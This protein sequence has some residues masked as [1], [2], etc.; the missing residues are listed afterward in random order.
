MENKLKNKIDRV[1]D[2]DAA[3]VILTLAWPTM[4]ESL[5]DTAV[6]Y[7]DTAMVGSLGTAATAAVGCTSTVGWLVG[8]SVSALG[9]GFLSYIAKALG[10]K[11]RESARR[12]AAQAVTVTA[13]VGLLF[14]VLTM[15][16]A[17]YVPVWMKADES[18]RK[19]ASVY[20][21]ILYAP[22]LFRSAKIIFG[23]LLRAAGDTKTPMRVGIGMNLI[24]VVLN[25]FLIYSS[26]PLW[27]LG[28]R[29]IYIYGAGLGVVGAALA[30][31]ISFVFGGIVIGRALWRHETISP[32]GHSYKPDGEILKPCLK[33]ALPN[34]L[35][36]FCTS[37]GY[38]VFASM[39][40][41]LG[42]L[43]TAAHTVA[44][45]V[46]SA[47]YIPG[48]G[49]Q[50]AAAT[51]TG[52]CIGAK[53]RARLKKLTANIERLEAAMMVVSG[54]LLF[55]FAPQMVS[56]FSDDPRVIALGGRVLRMVALS[57]PFY[58]V[59]VVTEG[60]L[61]GAGITKTPFLF[62]LL[63][64]WGIRIVGTYICIHVFALG[65]ISAWGCMIGNN[66]MLLVLFRIYWR[67]RRER[68]CG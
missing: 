21:T 3:A 10:A 68:L 20:F 57:E 16:L 9:I 67:R 54:G 4:L 23:T 40:N 60:M 13:V 47:F 41:S 24:N 18:I 30:S 19:T 8:S 25:F 5:M 46:E 17:G 1:I 38:V 37:L 14:T 33:V 2:R 42:E 28:G 61:Q 22:M 36:R 53:D 51:L 52:N 6:Q 45:T 56:L 50:A 49:M 32:R 58:G 7:V 59:S 55:A 35:Q 34:M 15:A 64:M 48:Y 39:I 65:L 12:A 11:D 66:M 27:K 26:R 43:S 44:N 29:Q 62:N 31:A 63:C